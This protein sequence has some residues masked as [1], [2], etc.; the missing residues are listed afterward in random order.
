MQILNRIFS[1]GFLLG[2]LLAPARA[3]PVD[4]SGEL[5]ALLAGAKTL[6]A[7]FVQDVRNERGELLQHTEG[8]MHVAR[9]QLFRWEVQ[10]PMPQLIV[11]DAH[12]VQ[13]YDPDLLQVVVRPLDAQVAATPALL[14]SGDA[15]R[16][17]AH[18]A[19]T[20]DGKSVYRL[21]P[22]DADAVFESL[23]VQFRNG[24]LA[25]MELH[26]ALG[27]TT[28]IDFRDVKQNEALDPALF[29]FTP[30]PGVDVVRELP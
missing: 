8:V 7:T 13:V 10:S 4:A 1:G 3:E 17:G 22:R 20:A 6:Q 28:R 14:F 23:D 16:I 5:A 21:H 12:Q 29:S 18:F 15:A 25:V 19:V 2:V 26:D 27:Q 9:P 24:V 30:P 11:A